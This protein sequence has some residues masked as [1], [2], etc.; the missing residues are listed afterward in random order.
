M[1]TSKIRFSQETA[2]REKI[3]YIVK[4]KIRTRFFLTAVVLFFSFF[5]PSWGQSRKSAQSREPVASDFISVPLCPSD[6][7]LPGDTHQIVFYEGFS[8]CYRESYEQAEWVSYFLTRE[9]LDGTA[10]RADNFRYDPN[11]DTGSAVPGDYR[12]SGYDRGHLA[13]AADMVFSEQVMGES[14]FMSN[15][16]PQDPSFNRGIWNRL[17]ALVRR[18]ALTL[19]SLYVVTG[20]VL[21]RECY[22]VIGDNEIAVPEYFYKVL[23]HYDPGETWGIGFIIPNRKCTVSSSAELL[24]TFAVTIDEVEE[25][26][27]IDFFFL[28]D[29]AIQAGFEGEWDAAFWLALP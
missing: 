19:G 29:E 8:L 1:H 6:T 7:G 2:E 18:W 15:M 14:F 4:M 27:G 12:G 3:C 24:E 17:E 9:K 16:S 13:P 26:T 22:P 10:M 20:P 25:R 23:L 5:I 28:L 11:I 21:E